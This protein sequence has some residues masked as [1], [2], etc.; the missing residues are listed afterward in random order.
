MRFS[1]IF[2][3]FLL[4]FQLCGQDKKA[5][6][7]FNEARSAFAAGNIERSLSLLD[8]AINRD[9]TFPDPALMAAQIWEERKNIEQANLYLDKAWAASQKAY[10]A[11]Q[12]GMINY[13]AGEYERALEFLELY[14]QHEEAKVVYLE[15]ANAAILNCLF[16]IEALKNPSDIHP[17]NLG[18]RV[19]SSAMEYFPAISADGQTLVFTYRNLEGNRRDEDFYFSEQTTAGWSQAMPLPG[20]LNTELNEGAQ[21]VTADGMQLIFVGCNRSEGKGSCDLYTAFRTDD[22]RWSRAVNMGDSINSVNWETQPSISP[23]GQTLYFIRANKREPGQ[24]DIYFSTRKAEGGWSKARKMPDNINTLGKEASPFIHFDNQ[25][26]YFCSDGHIGMGNTDLFVSRKQPDGSWSD[27]VNLGA[28]I[29]GPGEELGL[30]IAS[31]GKTAFY[32]SDMQGGLGSLDLYSFEL[33]ESFRAIPSAWVK[34]IVR[35]AASKQALESDL[36]FIDLKTGKPFAKVRSGKDGRYFAVLPSNAD[37]GLSVEKEGFLF[38]SENFALQSQPQDRAFQLDVNLQRL[39]KGSTIVL[40]NVFFAT[41][42]FELRPASFVELDKIAQLLQ[43]NPQLRIS[44]EGHTDNE[45]DQ[46]ANQK[47]SEN[48]AKAVRDYL[49][50]KGIAAER[51]QYKGFGEDRPVADNSTAAGRQKNRRTEL[52]IL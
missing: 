33:P 21:C 5:R 1:F 38:H 27:P 35:D 43:R 31:D 16:A 26:F 42:S 15:A 18:P 36:F 23:D 40:Q 45:G 4:T 11:F 41:A 51:L 19:N 46:L 13:R 12:I 28:P 7:Y 22:G 6:K 48:R 37:Y 30:V 10:I 9:D 32:S 24:S 2:C 3:A 52:R 25:T 17:E 14:T 39:E 50:T 44:L 20:Q 34:G 49:K 8:K 47:L 29:N